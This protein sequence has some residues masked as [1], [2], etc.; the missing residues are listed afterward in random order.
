GGIHLAAQDVGGLEQVAFQLGQGQ[1]HGFLPDLSWFSFQIQ[2]FRIGGVFV[3]VVRFMPSSCASSAPSTALSKRGARRA[4]GSVA[5]AI[6]QNCTSSPPWRRSLCY[7]SF[8][9]CPFE[10][11]VVQYAR[12][13]NPWNVEIG[14]RP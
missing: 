2:Q 1:W 12:A 8:S 11:L 4:A 10:H 6:C 3:D 9:T 13:Q 7:C 14:N 5:A